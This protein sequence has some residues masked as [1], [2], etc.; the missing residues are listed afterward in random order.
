MKALVIY[1]HPNPGS[2]CRA[3]REVLQE[4]FLRAEVSC[5]IRDLY[6]MGFDPVL[7]GEELKGGKKWERRA[8]IKREQDFIHEAD[9]L[10]FLF[11]LWWSGA[12]AIL[13]G[14]LDRVLTYGFA[15]AETAHGLAGLLTGKKAVIYTTTGSS[16]E[17]L[18]RQK[19]KEAIHVVF[20]A[21][22]FDFCGIQLC[23]SN[24]FHSVPSSTPEERLQ[25][26]EQARHSIQKVIADVQA[27]LPSV[28]SSSSALKGAKGESAP[29]RNLL[30]SGSTNAQP[31]HLTD[32]FRKVI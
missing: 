28:P 29:S 27:L 25:L 8:E 11:P 13:K 22:V 19:L 9:L 15:F 1:A 6:S 18:V 14:Y 10:V 31:H 5:V 26:L 17:E 21:G 23:E 7:R 32:P 24:Y 12:P 3:I 16:E 20:S 4:E 30:R 2:F